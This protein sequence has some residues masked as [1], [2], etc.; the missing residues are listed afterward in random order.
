M[1]VPPRDA[2]AGWRLLWGLSSVFRAWRPLV[3]LWG[4]GGLQH[5]DIHAVGLFSPPCA[6]WLVLGA[7]VSLVASLAAAAVVGVCVGGGGGSG[8]VCAVS[9]GWS[10]SWASMGGLFFFYLV[11]YIYS[12]LCNRKFIMDIVKVFY[13]FLSRP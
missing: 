3:G 13:S 12:I 6:R 4:T 9:R 7:V 2:D 11:R 1:R 8:G 10:P 5:G